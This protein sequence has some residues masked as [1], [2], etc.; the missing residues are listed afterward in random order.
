MRRLVPQKQFQDGLPV[1]QGVGTGSHRGMPIV[2]AGYSPC[3]SG[4]AAR[5]VCGPRH[6]ARSKMA[7]G[8]SATL[9]KPTTAALNSRW[10]ATLSKPG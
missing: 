9:K 10:N 5:T 4:M 7:Q 3:C 2:G 8:F 1:G 6:S